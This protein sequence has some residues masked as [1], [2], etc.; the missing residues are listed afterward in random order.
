MALYGLNKF[1][2]HVIAGRYLFESVA[3]TWSDTTVG[4]VLLVAA[5][6][7][8]CGCLSH[9]FYF[10]LPCSLQEKA[11]KPTSIWFLDRRFGAYFRG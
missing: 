6:V 11:I 4:I 3:N 8:L 5:L 9:K 10:R 2:I 7:V 1:N